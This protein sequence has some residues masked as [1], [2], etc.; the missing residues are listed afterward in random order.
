MSPLIAVFGMGANTCFALAIRSYRSAKHQ[1]QKPR[2]DEGKG[3]IFQRLNEHRLHRSAIRNFRRGCVLIV[4][5]V[6]TYL[7]K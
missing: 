6:I 7:L 1:S 4:A 3:G 2:L 5:G